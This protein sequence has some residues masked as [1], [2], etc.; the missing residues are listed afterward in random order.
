MKILRDH[1]L[2]EFAANFGTSLLT[3]LFI[4]LLG[5][6][7]IQ[8]A[9]LVF[10]KNVDPFLILKILFYSLPFMLTF[11]IPMSVLVATLMTFGKLSYDNELMAIRASGISMA[12][13]TVPVLAAVV[14][15]SLFSYLLADRIASESHYV[16]RRLLM[17]VGIESPAAALEEGTFIK[18]FKNFV[19]FI[20]EIDGNKLRGIRIYQPQEGRPT[21]TIIAESGELISIPEKN[22]IKLKLNRGTS[23]EP[24]P[25]DPS[26]L[27]KLNFK[28]YDLPLNL[29]GSRQYEELGKKPKDM[30]VKELKSEIIR[31]G[32]SGIHD[33]Y[34]LSAEIHNKAAL[35]LSSVAFA[36]VGIP[37]GIATKRREKTVGFGISL[38]LMTLYWTLLIA[39]KSLA[40]KG[41]APPF[42]SLQF[43]NLIIGGLGA[44]LFTR[45]VRD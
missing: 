35:A 27:Y 43:S 32:D 45:V 41:L 42:L 1:V 10:N 44:W 28:T 16:Y 39:G 31:L 15:M 17:Q 36:L 20:Y 34:P 8:M 18:K 30:T 33:A 40:Q 21:R 14:L 3:F 5:R 2:K 6:G 25:K 37:L 12:R 23:D 13:T 29:T 22:I 19:I 24:D 26:R 4:F 7:F 38:A 9:D 11:I